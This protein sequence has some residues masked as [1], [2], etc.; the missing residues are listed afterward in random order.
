[1][2]KIN[3][4]PQFAQNGASIQDLRQQIRDARQAN[5]IERRE[6]RLSNR[7]S[8]IQGNENTPIIDENT[9][10]IDENR[11]AT[12]DGLF[13]IPYLSQSLFPQPKPLQVRYLESMQPTQETATPVAESALG[14]TNKTEEDLPIG[15]PIRIAPVSTRTTEITTVLPVKSDADYKQAVLDVIRGKYG[16]GRERLNKLNAAGFDPKKVQDAVNA[17]LG[18]TAA[19]TLIIDTPTQDAIPGSRTDSNSNTTE[20]INSNT[21]KN[22]VDLKSLADKWGPKAA[23]IKP[24]T[25]TSVLKAT[26][27][28]PQPNIFGRI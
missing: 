13:S 14:N 28:R 6:N 4:L 16:N 25:D 17:K 11:P 23:G 18:K 15:V 2:Y 24:I 27:A 9:P 10:V 21:T 19:N 1:M 12:T 3:Y 7:L 20:N 5:R 8:R 22:T 26:P